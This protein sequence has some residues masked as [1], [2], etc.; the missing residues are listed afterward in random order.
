MAKDP[1]HVLS[2]LRA[3]INIGGM[4]IRDLGVGQHPGPLATT[5]EDAS[6]VHTHLLRITLKDNTG[7]INLIV[8]GAVLCH[9]FDPLKPETS[10]EI[11]NFVVAEDVERFQK[12]FPPMIRPNGITEH[13]TNKSI[14]IIASAA[15][16]PDLRF[17]YWKAEVSVPNT[18][19]ADSV[20]IKRLYARS[21]PPT[22]KPAAL[23]SVRH[24]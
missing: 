3:S 21:E 11:C 1:L 6:R 20:D 12:Y 23:A 10:V 14:F 15:Q 24:R 17:T 9:A 5:I 2:S 16:R 19:P 18:V 13:G 8:E 22:T 4:K 7:L